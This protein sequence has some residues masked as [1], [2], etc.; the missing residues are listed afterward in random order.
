MRNDIRKLQILVYNYM[1]ENKLTQEKFAELGAPEVTRG[2]LGYLL[3]GNATAIDI[4]LL[5][6]YAKAL[7]LP[8]STLAASIGVPTATPA[9]SRLGDVLNELQEL[10]ELVP[11]A[12]KEAMIHELEEVIERAR[13]TVQAS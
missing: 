11:L 7:R 5:A 8:F 13:T 2:K 10:G 3:N 4:A 6:G 12:Q 9:T 1:K